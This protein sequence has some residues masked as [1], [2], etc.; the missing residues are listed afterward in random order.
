MYSCKRLSS[1]YL[2]VT[3]KVKKAEE[4]QR[5]MASNIKGLSYQVIFISD[6]R[7]STLK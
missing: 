5:D 7:A 3:R 2:D 4:E 1:S 6:F